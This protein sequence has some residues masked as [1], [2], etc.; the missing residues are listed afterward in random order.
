MG[1]GLNMNEVNNSDTDSKQ[2]ASEWCESKGAGWSIADELGKG[3]TAPVFEVN[4]PE[5]QFALKIYDTAFST[6]TKGVI[7][8][9]RIEQQ[10]KLK[11]H[12]CESLVKIYDGGNFKNRL[13]LLMERADG[14]ELEKCLA[15]IPKDKIRHIVDQIA[16]AVLFLKD[17]NL[18]HRDIKAANIYV[19]NDC[20]K[21]T[22]LDISVIRDIHDPIGVGTDHD[23]QL[24]IVA[25]ARYS[26][27]EYLFRL[28]EPGPELWH[29]LNVYQMG[30]LLHDLIVGEP[31]FQKEYL[32]SKENRYR[33][34]WIVATTQPEMSSVQIDKDLIFLANRALDKDWKRRSTLTI[35]EFLSSATAKQQHAL[36]LIGLSKDKKVAQGYDDIAAI[37]RRVRAVAKFVEDTMSNHLRENGITV[38]HCIN[39]GTTDSSKLIRFSWT[40]K[41]SESSSTKLNVVYEIPISMRAE[42]SYYKFQCSAKLS[43]DEDGKLVESAIDLPDTLDDS[44][45]ETIIVAQVKSALDTLAIKLLRA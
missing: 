19:S 24:P 27:P 45:A 36:Q 21:V 37:L 2:I 44:N 8:S 29:A 9:K 3:G 4:S 26:P 28:L 12:T 38:E 20:N 32:L 30:A 39:Y 5:G 6:G 13:W 40:I 35:E 1:L 16:R 7:E 33:F 43:C 42:N 23:G 15:L 22:L 31:I 14:R 11:G 17:N 10:L 34:A 18:C 25:T 41:Q